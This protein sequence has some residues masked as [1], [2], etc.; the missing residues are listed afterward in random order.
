MK[1]LLLVLDSNRLLLTSPVRVT[2][3]TAQEGSGCLEVFLCLKI[4]LWCLIQTVSNSSSSLLP[5]QLLTRSRRQRHI[6]TKMQKTEMQVRVTKAWKMKTSSPER[7]AMYKTVEEGIT[8]S[9][10]LAI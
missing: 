2:E 1:V 10:P 9:S 5:L 8:L 3:L 6:L 7:C 4:L